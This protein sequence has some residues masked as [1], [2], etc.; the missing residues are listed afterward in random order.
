MIVIVGDVVSGASLVQVN[1]GSAVLL[2]PAASENLP[3]ATYN[4]VSPY[5]NGV[6]VMV[7]TVLEVAEKLLKSPLPEIS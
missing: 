5:E 1:C 3:A 6:K 7:Y 4:L 2:L